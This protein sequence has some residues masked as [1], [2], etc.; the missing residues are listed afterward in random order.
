MPYYDMMLVTDV[1]LFDLCESGSFY[2]GPVMIRLI[3]PSY[4]EQ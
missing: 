4:V 3:F 2:D 1:H